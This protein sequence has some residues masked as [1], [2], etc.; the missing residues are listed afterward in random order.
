[1][2]TFEWDK[3]AER[4]EIHTDKAGL[5]GLIAQLS[6]LAESDG[7]DHLCLMTEAWGG[8]D[9]TGEPQNEDAVF[10]NQVKIFKWDD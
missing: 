2:L 1:M 3:D 8:G 7:Q 9:L 5:L 4:M 6:Q 10:M